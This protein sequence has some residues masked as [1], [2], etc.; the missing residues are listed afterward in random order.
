MNS[1]V[2]SSKTEQKEEDQQQ[3]PGTIKDSTRNI[4]SN[5]KSSTS[6]QQLYHRQ[7]P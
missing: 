6:I 5:I 7:Q 3:Q 4:N 1:G 2:I